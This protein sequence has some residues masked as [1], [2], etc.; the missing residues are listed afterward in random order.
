V[1]SPKVL[2][3][4]LALVLGA[5][6]YSCTG[7]GRRSADRRDAA[8][9]RAIAAAAFPVPLA[10]LATRPGVEVVDLEGGTR[11]CPDRCPTTFVRVSAAAAT[12][13]LSFAALLSRLSSAGWG[14][15]SSQESASSCTAGPQALPCAFTRSTAGSILL[16]PGAAGAYELSAA[17]TS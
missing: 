6:A 8:S 16:R 11:G 12:G 14:L 15:G 3:L 7:G 5:V 10:D 1:R 17:A 4:L 9:A 13:D 2:A